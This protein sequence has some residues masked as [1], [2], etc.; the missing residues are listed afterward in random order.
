MAFTVNDVEVIF[1]PEDRAYREA[2]GALA[3][4]LDDLQEQ[5]AR[6]LKK[7]RKCG[8]KTW[9]KAY[10]AARR[11][12]RI[13]RGK[14]DALLGIGVCAALYGNTQ[15]T[16]AGQGAPLWFSLLDALYSAMDVQ[17]RPKDCEAVIAKYRTKRVARTGR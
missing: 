9:A 13:M 10:E 7:S 17:L 2:F 1:T 6:M 16:A 4:D 14:M 15:L 11:T 3:C 12:D 5:L 8:G